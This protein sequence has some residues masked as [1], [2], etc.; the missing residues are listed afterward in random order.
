M[1][2]IEV[3]FH[4]AVERIQKSKRGAFIDTEEPR[5]RYAG[6]AGKVTD[7]KSMAFEWS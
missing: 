1:L 5:I 7:W 2:Q 6:F 4:A 3:G